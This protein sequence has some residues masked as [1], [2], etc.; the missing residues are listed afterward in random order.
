M[1]TQHG[2]LVNLL[3]KVD[4]AFFFLI[5][6][7]Y[8]IQ[9]WLLDTFIL[10]PIFK[11]TITNGRREEEE[12]AKVEYARSAQIVNVIGRGSYCHA[13][14]HSLDNYFYRHVK[15]VHPRHVLKA[16]NI[17]LQGVTPTHAFFCVSAKTDVYATEKAP[18]TFLMQYL[19]AEQLV[20]MPLKSL[21]RLA[22]EIGD[23]DVDTL[24]LVNNTA[25]S[26]ST[27]LCQM[28]ARVP[29]VRVMSEPWALLHLHG[30][31]NQGR[32]ETSEYESLIQSVVRIQ[33][34]KEHERGD[35]P[36]ALVIKL[37]FPCAPQFKILKEK[38]PG[39]K[40]IFMTRHPKASN[41]SFLRVHKSFP[42]I[43][44][45]LSGKAKEFVYEHLPIP[46]DDKRL[47]G[48]RQSFFPT[49]LYLT[50]NPQ[51]VARGYAGAMTCYLREKQIY[52]KVL[53]Y[54]DFMEKPEKEMAAT[55]EILNLPREDVKKALKALKQ[56]PQNDMFEGKEASISAEE[57]NRANITYD[58]EFQLSFNTE[59]TMNKFRKEMY[60]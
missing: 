52:D 59:S 4:P 17:T 37:P 56:G 49:L 29:G 46:Y 1:A 53:I 39:A 19:S 24:A 16:D 48:F 47:Q 5:M 7:F 43:Y 13:S 34:K 18:F 60:G 21:V 6:K 31:Y 27:L 30:H 41:A 33:G 20:I 23:P 36:K 51:N 35:R 15:Y 54:E 8:R 55:L 32:L 40:Y 10:G 58:E 45:N 57:W 22:D 42:Y 44:T 25:R 50:R 2:F 12:R 11:L 14:K 3:L 26:G 9:V 38:F 28:L